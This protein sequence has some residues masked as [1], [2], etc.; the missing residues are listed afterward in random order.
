MKLNAPQTQHAA[1]GGGIAAWV[2][3]RLSLARPSAMRSHLAALNLLPQIS[4]RV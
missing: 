2:C 4:V 3:W 1:L